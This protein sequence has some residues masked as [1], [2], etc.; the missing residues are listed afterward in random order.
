[1]IVVTEDKSTNIVQPFQE[2]ANWC[3][4]T[5]FDLGMPL[6]CIVERNKT[7][8]VEITQ[9]ALMLIPLN[10]RGCMIYCEPMGRHSSSITEYFEFP[11]LLYS[12]VDYG[13][14]VLLALKEFTDQKRMFFLHLDEDSGDEP[15]EFKA[16]RHINLYAISKKI[17]SKQ[18]LLLARSSSETLD[19]PPKDHGFH[20]SRDIRSGSGGVVAPDQIPLL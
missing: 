15:I 8:S 14:H 13:E 17:S 6:T 16:S 9:I 3:R 7:K 18:S 2:E 19:E 20:S 5:L 10:N 11:M 1:M 4:L 12:F